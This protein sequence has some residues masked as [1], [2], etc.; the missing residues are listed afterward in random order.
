MINVDQRNRWSTENYQHVY[1]RDG[2]ACRYCGASEDLTID[3][4][5]PRCQGGGDGAENL[6]VACRAC[7]SRK[8]GRTP[9]QA[10]MVLQ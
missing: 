3:H 9:A 10:G 5:L 8:G 6:A 1:E 2:K 4:V 7:N